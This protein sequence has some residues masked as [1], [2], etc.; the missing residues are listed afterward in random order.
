MKKRWTFAIEIVLL[1]AVLAWIGSFVLVRNP[2]SP[3]NSVAIKGQLNGAKDGID[4]YKNEKGEIRFRAVTKDGKPIDYTADDFARTYY[5]EGR[6]R[7]G[8]EKLLNISSPE[9]AAWVFLGLL[10]QVLFTGRMVVQ[11]LASEKEKKSIVPPAFWWMSLAGATMLLIYFGWRR[12]PI[13]V[14]GQSFGWFIYVRNLYLIYNKP[15]GVKP[16]E[17]DPVEL[18][19]IVAQEPS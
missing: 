6:S 5:E 13:G 11:I 2:Y 14:L 10:G 9:G 17:A 3:P 16:A 8:W 7:A 4:V 18:K 15:E 1:V 12:D 19:A